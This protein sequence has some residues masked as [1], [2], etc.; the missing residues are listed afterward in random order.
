VL[1]SDEGE[2]DMTRLNHLASSFTFVLGVVL[3]RRLISESVLDSGY[4]VDRV[5]PTQT[6]ALPK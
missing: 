6:P 4:N 3:S 1:H 5:L 2:S